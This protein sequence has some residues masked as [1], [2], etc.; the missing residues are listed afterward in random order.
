MTQDVSTTGYDSPAYSEPPN[1]AAT[2]DVAKDQA[3]GVA[4]NAKDA[5]QHV[6]GVAKQEAGNVASEA[7]RQ[8]KDVAGQAR[9]EISRQANEQQQRVAGGLRSIG[10]EIGSMADRSES[11]GI[12]TDL[13]RQASSKVQ[14]V[15]DWLESQ[16]PG[17]LVEEVK[18]FARRRPGAFLAIALGAGVVAGRLTRGIK[19]ESSN[20]S[21]GSGYTSR[22]ATGYSGVGTEGYATGT[23]AGYSTGTTGEYATGTTGG[24]G[25]G[26]T[27][28]YS[29]G[30]ADPAAPVEP[31]VPVGGYAEKDFVETD[32]PETG[33]RAADPAFPSETDYPA[34][35]TYRDEENR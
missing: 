30:L 24:Y 7:T 11:S 34:T 10:T 23:T 5:G 4:S 18:T 2:K 15:A 13:A 20:G 35:P 16:D 17:T 32:Y 21:S 3:A 8:V 28:G 9:A 31:A 25:T 14:E 29:T 6:A 1:S 22:N 33:Y 19:D 26:A 27:A 12:A